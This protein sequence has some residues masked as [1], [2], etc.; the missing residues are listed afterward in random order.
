MEDPRRAR[1]LLRLETFM[2]PRLYSG[3]A[4]QQLV[5]LELTQESA[6]LLDYPADVGY[7]LNPF[8]Q[9]PKAMVNSMALLPDLLQSSARVFFADPDG[10]E[11][12]AWQTLESVL[13]FQPETVFNTL[14][15]KQFR[16]SEP[17]GGI[18]S[19]FGV[20]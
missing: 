16:S 13:S 6:E 3:E 15:L 9:L 4:L 19:P 7:L 18:G 8:L 12:N 14:N 1:R 20:R 5:L 2:F 17:A 10:A 11:S